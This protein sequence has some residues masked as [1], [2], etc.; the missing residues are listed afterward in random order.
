MRF[1]IKK[2][3]FLAIH[4]SE[5]EKEERERQKRE[6]GRER[7]REREKGNAFS[8]RALPL[9]SHRASSAALIPLLVV[10]ALSNTGQPASFTWPIMHKGN[11]FSQGSVKAR[12]WD[13][14]R[15][16]KAFKK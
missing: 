16:K 9:A 11:Q 13:F 10:M 8:W 15:V 2:A 14:V 1:I 7:E 5:R 4:A 3:H 12:T 6:K